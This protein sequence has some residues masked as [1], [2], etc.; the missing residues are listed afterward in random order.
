MFSGAL[1]QCLK[2]GIEGASKVLTL[3]EVGKRAR[4]IIVERFPGDSVRPELHVPEQSLGDPAKVPL[5]PN[6]RWVDTS[7]AEHQTEHDSRVSLGIAKTTSNKNAPSMQEMT[8]NK[9]DLPI[10]DPEKKTS[11]SQRLNELVFRHRSK[12]LAFLGA[13][14]AVP[15][16]AWAF[17]LFS[18]R[19]P[20]P[21]DIFPQ[22]I[23]VMR[24]SDAKAEVKATFSTYNKDQNA[25][26][27]NC[28]MDLRA[29]RRRVYQSNETYWIGTGVYRGTGTFDVLG[30][31]AT[32][33]N[34]DYEIRIRCY[35]QET[36]W[37]E[38]PNSIISFKDPN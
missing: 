22:A 13:I 1:L 26:N 23:E 34:A 14:V 24:F 16:F 35:G 8:P 32:R 28:Q 33:F 31:D 38:A 10:D 4:E 18:S 3:E 17:Q 9:I 12:L 21:I 36:E 29:N 30:L 15:L 37:L 7:K 5:F 2:E 25:S 20:L 19:I 11:F 27:K 6:P